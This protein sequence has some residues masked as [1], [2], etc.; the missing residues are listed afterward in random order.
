MAKKEATIQD[1]VNQFM[2]VMTR[3]KVTGFKRNDRVLYA[4]TAK[5]NNLLLIPDIA[6]WNEL[7]DDPDLNEITRELNPGVKEDAYRLVMTNVGKHMDDEWIP[8]DDNK[9]LNDDIVYVK[10]EGF[11]YDIELNKTIFPL[12]FKKAEW[13]NFAYNIFDQPFHSFAIRKQFVSPIEDASFY[14]VRVFRII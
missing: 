7:C 10:V 13:G 3:T 9:M 2:D 14:V 11:E 4:E 5:C 1:A 12:R 8:I 6:L